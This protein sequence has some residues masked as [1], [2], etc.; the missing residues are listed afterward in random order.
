[1]CVCCMCLCAKPMYRS[2]SSIYSLLIMEP[3]VTDIFLPTFFKNKILKTTQV[4]MQ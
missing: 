2:Q 1:M 4:L 3:K